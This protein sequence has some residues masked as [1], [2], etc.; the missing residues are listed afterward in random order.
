MNSRMNLSEILEENWIL[1]SLLFELHVLAFSDSDEG[2][3]ILL[4]FIFIFSSISFDD[5]LLW[6]LLTH[7]PSL[8]PQKSWE[9]KNQYWFPISCISWFF[10]SKIYVKKLEAEKSD[11]GISIFA[12]APHWSCTSWCLSYNIHLTL[13]VLL[14]KLNIKN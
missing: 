8:G 12:S 14:K 5:C 7:V 3:N 1:D 4:C 2:H 13:P 10:W 6:I 9:T 11:L